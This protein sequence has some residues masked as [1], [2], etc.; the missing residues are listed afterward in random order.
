MLKPAL[1]VMISVAVPAA[2]ENW[3]NRGEYDRVLEIKAEATPA[4]RLALLDQW[5]K[6]YPKTELRQA[7]WELYLPTYQSLGSWDRMLAVA[8]EMAADAPT[9]PVG[10][11]WIAL[12]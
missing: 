4:K 9:A 6:E 2:G 3:T 12:L 7:R 1:L 5:K 11:Y 10:M 8:H